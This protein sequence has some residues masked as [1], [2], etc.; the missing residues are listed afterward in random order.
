M[1]KFFPQVSEIAIVKESFYN[2]VSINVSLAHLLKVMT[3]DGCLIST[4]CIKEIYLTKSWVEDY[5]IV[6]YFE[7]KQF[8][9]RR[10]ATD[11]TPLNHFIY[12]VYLPWQSLQKC[13]KVGKLRSHRGE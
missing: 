4:D 5:I 6:S 8:Q 1:M 9:N 13:K 7:R 3:S 11:T 2:S 10:I 12:A